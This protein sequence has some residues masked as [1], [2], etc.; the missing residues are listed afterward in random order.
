V[1]SDGT[2]YAIDISAATNVTSNASLFINNYVYKTG[3]SSADAVRV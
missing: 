1:I 3:A 2:S